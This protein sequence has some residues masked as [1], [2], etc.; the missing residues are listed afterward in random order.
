[1]LLTR[2]T[3]A[4][5]FAVLLVLPTICIAKP[6]VWISMGVCLDSN[7][8]FNGKAK[9]PY[10][11][12]A[13]YATLLW[14]KVTDANVIVYIVTE[15]PDGAT[16]LK[17]ALS[18]AGAHVFLQTPI[19]PFSCA[20][21]S[22]VVRMLAYRER[23]IILSSDIIVTADVDAFPKT[24]A[25]MD[26]LKDQN[27]L[28]WLWQHG[29]SQ[30]TGYTFPMSF[31]GTY[32]CM[33]G[34]LVDPTLV[35]DPV[36]IFQYWNEVLTIPIQRAGNE[37]GHWG[38]D[39]MVVSRGILQHGFCNVNV[40]MFQ[41]LN[42]AQPSHV[43]NDLCYTGDLMNDLP[44]N[45][46]AKG[47]WHHFHPTDGR[48]TLRASFHQIA[49][50]IEWNV[51]HINH[52]DLYRADASDPAAIAAADVEAAQIATATGKSTRTLLRS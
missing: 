15:N 29:Y 12:A 21:T 16:H 30:R 25:I 32:S 27:K 37:L 43:T 19:K 26:P 41:A 49:E 23:S 4:L 5:I 48:D 3:A 40:K 14:R 44:G 8:E 11:L 1:M 46:G 39:Q 52:D 47:T 33:W 28:F 31:I 2:F 17:K 9:F 50:A 13:I 42:L 35:E 36:K 20:T 18:E 51:D 7:V 24:P 10:R 45:A 34:K 6:N 38:I 22:Q